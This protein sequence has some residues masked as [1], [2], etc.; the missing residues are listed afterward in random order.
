MEQ[1]YPKH[2]LHLKP[3]H[4]K[5]LTNMHAIDPDDYE[6]YLEELLDS[7][8]DHENVSRETLP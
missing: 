6:S 2:M 7:Q 8:V 5:E 3:K 1:Q 4:K